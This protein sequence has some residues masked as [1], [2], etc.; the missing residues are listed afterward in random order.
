MC[1]CCKSLS[2]MATG[3]IVTTL[4]GCWVATD[5]ASILIR[6]SSS[7]K[8]HRILNLVLPQ[9]ESILAGVTGASCDLKIGKQ[10][11]QL[12][13]AFALQSLLFQIH[14]ASAQPLE[15]KG[16]EAVRLRLVERCT[17][18][19]V[20]TTV[21]VTVPGAATVEACF[22]SPVAQLTMSQQLRVFSPPPFSSAAASVLSRYLS[23]LSVLVSTGNPSVYDGVCTFLL[24]LVDRDHN[25]SVV[26]PHA[27]VI[28]QLLDASTVSVEIQRRIARIRDLLC[29]DAD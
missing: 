2:V 11:Q 27:V 1:G 24:D 29:Q 13:I 9:I 23:K 26:A 3:Q 7:D 16:E 10:R 8:P 6:S 5:I 20:N 21:A 12:M 19:L 17:E 4:S 22:G 14:T 25:L 28:F 15:D 18:L